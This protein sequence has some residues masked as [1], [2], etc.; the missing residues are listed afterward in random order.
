MDQL[1]RPDFYGI[2]EG[3]VGHDLALQE[4]R[5]EIAPYLSS[6]VRGCPFAVQL[7]GVVL[8][9]RG[10]PE[11]LVFELADLGNLEQH[12]G[13]V[14]VTAAGS[15]PG[16]SFTDIGWWMCDTVGGVAHMHH[17]GPEAVLHR[18]LKLEN[19]LLFAATRGVGMA[20]VLNTVAG[21]GAGAGTGTAAGAGADSG[22]GEGATGT[23]VVDGSV[24]DSGGVSTP[25]NA[26]AAPPRD[27]VK[28]ADMGLAKEIPSH[29]LN[30]TSAPSRGNMAG[31]APQADR[32]LYDV[33]GDVYA[34]AVTMLTAVVGVRSPTLHVPDVSYAG[35]G[36]VAHPE[37][38]PLG[39]ACGV[40]LLGFFHVGI[41]L[42]RCVTVDLWPLCS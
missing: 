6:A 22:P 10:R 7:L 32:G 18:D 37:R 3:T 9:H 35:R 13:A 38:T 36:R 8:D 4:V 29:K 14:A 27:V 24:A 39:A 17:S 15:R 26:R 42:P 28:V 34:W 1:E 2:E 20:R 5:D 23:A 31:R 19:M 16:G 30:L 11:K 12:V 21:A 40:R 25:G 41:S 33:Y